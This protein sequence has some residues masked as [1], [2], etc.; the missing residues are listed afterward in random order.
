VALGWVLA[1]GLVLASTG[2]TSGEEGPSDA[3]SSSLPSRSVQ[4]QATVEAEPVP[5]DV[6]VAT[7]VGNRLGRPRRAQLQQQVSR[8]L[9]DYFD[10]AYLGGDYPRTDFSAA[11]ESFSPGVARQARRDRALLSNAADGARVEAVV[12]LRKTARVDALVP[13]R[14]VA[15]LTARIRLVFVQ[16][17]S[18]GA[19]QRVTVSGRLLMNR[20]KAGPWQLF[21][22]D[23]TRTATP[24][25]KGTDR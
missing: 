15:G 23:V 3:A 4:P 7:V 18:D 11:W 10:A 2:C 21:G 16:Q 6:A 20:A 1:A 9:A 13:R 22:Y 14:V 19:D 24:T 12:P 8:V 17:M 25:G 5:M